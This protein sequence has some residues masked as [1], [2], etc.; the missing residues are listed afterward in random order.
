[1]RLS[2]LIN[3]YEDGNLS[4]LE[5]ATKVFSKYE[6]LI[7]Y[8]K[9]L[10]KSETKRII[11]N[12]EAVLFCISLLDLSGDEYSIYMKLC[13]N[14]VAQVPATITTFGRYEDE[15][16][17]MV[18]KIV[19]LL[20]KDAVLFD[21]GA[22]YGWYSLNIKKLYPEMEVY[23]FEPISETYSKMNYNFKIN[24]LEVNSYNIGFSHNAGDVD[25]YYDTVATG[26][27][28]MKNLRELDTTIIEKC[29]I[30]R[31]DEFIH[32]NDITRLDFIKC[33]VEGSELFV[34]QGG[35]NSIREYKPVV[36]SEMLRKW[37]AKFGYHPNDIIS[38]F[39]ELGYGC[40][41]MS[42]RSGLKEFGVVTEETIETNYFFL[43]KEKHSR[44][45]EE[46]VK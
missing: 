43:N 21:V 30:E 45:I 34:Y 8:S 4:K 20:P 37:S 33:D 32:A 15:E 1:M 36:F 13:E 25:F 6:E 41:V 42:E 29:H 18:S 22:N 38:F 3:N 12:K 35:M 23:A 9:L 28:S 16:L 44:I 17:K 39:A 11:I 46:L 27:S 2:E 14:D 10:S 26:A 19:K 5:Y 31:M 7:E 24:G 40:Y